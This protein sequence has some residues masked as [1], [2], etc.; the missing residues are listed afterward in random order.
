[1]KDHLK[2]QVD[3]LNQRFEQSDPQEILEYFLTHFK[4][5]IAFASSLGA[6]DQVITEMMASIDPAARIFTLDTGRMFPESYDVIERSIARYK[7]KIEIFFPEREAVEKM[8]NEKGINLFYESIENRKHCCHIRKIEPLNRALSGLDVWISGLRKSQSVTRTEIKLVEWDENHSMIKVNPLI[9]WNEEQV[10]DYIKQNNIPYNRLHD[11]GFP[12]IGC[13]PCTRAV[14]PGE[15][16]RAG[17]WWWEE[18]HHKECGL[19]VKK[20]G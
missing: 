11:Q 19:H 5:K 7:I 9:N 1:M 20:W 4:D 13:Q 6:E 16:V 15:D 18:V 12:S 8:V 3:R 10:W 14:Q 2:E 17:R